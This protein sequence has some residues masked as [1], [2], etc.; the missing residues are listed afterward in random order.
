MT[1]GTKE[2]VLRQLGERN[3]N[4]KKNSSMLNICTFICV[5]IVFNPFLGHSLVER[6]RIQQKDLLEGRSKEKTERN[7]VERKCFEKDVLASLLF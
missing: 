6:C 4:E 7:E 5:C 3:R 2:S 1:I